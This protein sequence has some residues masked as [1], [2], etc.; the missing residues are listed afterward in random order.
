MIASRVR[1]G[2]DARHLA[3]D[4]DVQIAFDVALSSA[5]VALRC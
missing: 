4:S 3:A 1:A 5:V 2:V